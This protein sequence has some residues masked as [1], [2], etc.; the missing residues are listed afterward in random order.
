M[1]ACHAVVVAR[2]EAQAV[3]A[4]ELVLISRDAV[5]AADVQPDAGEQRLPP[6]D[7]VGAHDGVA[8][9]ELEANVERGA[10]RRHDLVAARLAGGSTGSGSVNLPPDAERGLLTRPT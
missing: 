4:D 2:E 5:N 1:H 7:R 8:G 6:C 9:A 10:A 3:L